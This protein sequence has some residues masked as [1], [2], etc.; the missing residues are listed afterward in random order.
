[1]KIVT[2]TIGDRR[3]TTTRHLLRATRKHVD[4]KKDLSRNGCRKPCDLIFHWRE[5]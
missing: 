4:R 3:I 1:M 2:K 5:S